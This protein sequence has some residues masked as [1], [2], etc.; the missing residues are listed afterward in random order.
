MKP[1]VISLIALALSASV[2]AAPPK[3]PVGPDSAAAFEMLKSLAGE[4]RGNVGKPGNPGG[5]DYRVTA[6]GSVV[7]ETLFPGTDHEMI[8]MYFLNRGELMLT[9]YCAAGNQP[10]MLYDRKH[11]GSDELAF[12]FDGGRGFSMRDDLHIHNGAIKLHDA[13]HIEAEWTS[14]NQGKPGAT[15]HFV[16]TRVAK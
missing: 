14:W 6:G 11:S 15:H 12:K 16:L 8:S 1:I 7:M 2:H 3:P 10:E 9:H 5:I 13:R 4:W